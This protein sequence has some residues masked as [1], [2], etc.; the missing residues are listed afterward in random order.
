MNRSEAGKLGYQKSK[1]TLK[2]QLQE[3]ISNYC[4]HPVICAFCGKPLSYEKRFNKFCNHSCAASYNNSGAASHNNAQKSKKTYGT[5]LNCGK[6]LLHKGKYCNNKCMGE[7]VSN[8]KYKQAIKDWKEDKLP[9]TYTSN[10][11]VS[12]HIKKYLLEKF[13]HRC[14]K[15]GWH[16]INEYTGR[17]PLEV[18]HLDGNWKNNN[19]DNLVILCPN[20]HSLTNTYKGRN[21]GRG[22][23]TRL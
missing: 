20:C 17:I 22:R 6:P 9:Q 5:C 19:E 8:N 7:Y 13:N 15:C 2:K 23:S 16:E 11:L 21:R 18:H 14:A 3:R 1:A 4:L 10:G 12:S